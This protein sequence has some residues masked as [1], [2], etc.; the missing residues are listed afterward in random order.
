MF[1]IILPI[2]CHFHFSLWTL[3]CVHT[4]QY[5]VC[6]QKGEHI[7]FVCCVFFG[8]LSLF[9]CIFS[10]TKLVCAAVSLAFPGVHFFLRNR[11]SFRRKPRSTFHS[12]LKFLN[13]GS[14]NIRKN[15]YIKVVLWSRQ[16]EI[17]LKGVVLICDRLEQNPFCYSMHF[18]STLIWFY[19]HILLNSWCFPIVCGIYSLS[20]NPVRK[21]DPER[22]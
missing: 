22:G 19:S 2:H 11:F 21:T 10:L 9:K 18:N 6:V 5:F 15:K 17:L 20:L 12:L 7:F 3:L 4:F 8:S 13:V 16:I 1:W 14:N